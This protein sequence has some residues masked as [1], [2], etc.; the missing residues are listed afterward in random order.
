MIFESTLMIQTT[1][2][3]EMIDLGR[4]VK[5]EAPETKLRGFCKSKL[6]GLNHSSDIGD[7][8][9]AFECCPVDNLSDLLP[10]GGGTGRIWGTSPCLSK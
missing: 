9:D 5:M 8:K 3:R 10:E 4:G 2:G 1:W 6:E 7:D